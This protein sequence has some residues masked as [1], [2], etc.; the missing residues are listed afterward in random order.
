VIGEA[1][2]TVVRSMWGSASE[3]RHLGSATD[4][5]VP[6]WE[7]WSPSTVLSQACRCRTRASGLERWTTALRCITV[8]YGLFPVVEQPSERLESGTVVASGPPLS[9]TKTPMTVLPS[10][11]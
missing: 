8:G 6:R 3:G 5:G 7:R 11:S 10:L 4:N 1:S 2:L 9:L